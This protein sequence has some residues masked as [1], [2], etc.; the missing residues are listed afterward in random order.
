[1]NNVLV[2]CTACQDV[3]WNGWSA[4]APESELAVYRVNLAD[5]MPWLSPLRNV[6]AWDEIERALRYRRTDDEIRFSCTRALLRLLLARYTH[7]LPHE[8][9]FTTGAN[10]KPALQGPADWQFNVSH[11]G[12]WLLIAIGRAQVGVDLEWINPAFLFRDVFELSF[13]RAE[14]RYIELAV[15]ARQAFY[16]LWT[17]KEALVKATG[18]GMDDAFDQIPSLT[19]SHHSTSQVMGQAGGWQV[20]SFAVA[21]D[22]LA[23]VAHNGAPLPMPRFFTIDPGLLLDK[24]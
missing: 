1:M 7:Q 9:I 4:D 23:A 8:L 14:Q 18:K 10:R 16:G 13:S 15:D 24:G 6:L 20:I 22:Y 12:N 11:S 3:T 21:D 5:V 2:T 17:R 19:G